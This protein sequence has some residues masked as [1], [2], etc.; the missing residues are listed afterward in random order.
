MKSNS[1]ATTG[2]VLSLVATFF[3][4]IPFFGFVSII[5]SILA[6]VFGGIGLSASSELGGKGKALTSI[7]LSVVNIVWFFVAT[8][9]MASAIASI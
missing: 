6:I 4:M 7:V 2:L 5:L 8:L 1:K 9:I 3:N